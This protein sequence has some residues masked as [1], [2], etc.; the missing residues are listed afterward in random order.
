[1]TAQPMTQTPA[2]SDAAQPQVTVYSKPACVQCNGTYRWMEKSGVPFD[3]VDMSKDPDA[4]ERMRALGHMQAPVVEVRHPD[5]RK[6]YFTG[7]RPDLIGQLA[8]L[9]S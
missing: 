8:E 7:F 5:G 3:V 2:Q 9:F 6:D 4:L 1:M